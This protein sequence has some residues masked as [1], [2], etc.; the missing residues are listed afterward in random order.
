MPFPKRFCILLCLFQLS[1]CGG[2]LFAQTAAPTKVV[3]PNWPDMRFKQELFVFQPDGSPMKRGYQQVSGSPYLLPAC[4]KVTV[5]LTDIK[6]YVDVVGNLDLYSH[7]LIFL[8]DKNAPLLVSEERISEFKYADTI[9]NK[10]TFHKLINGYEPTGLTGRY[11]YFEVL[12]DGKISYLELKKV[13]LLESK[14]ELTGEKNSI[15]EAYRD[16]FIQVGGKLSRLGKRQKETL[17]AAM[18][19]KKDSVA[20]Y[21]Q[22]S[23]LTLRNNQEVM[24]LITYYNS[25]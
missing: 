5:Y 9:D 1:F 13:S 10:I 4:K 3:N 12:I 17:L 15:F 8:D 16:S 2:C 6:Q 11:D 7:E 19:D 22:K 20:A 23:R 21:V 24:Q 25:L 14:N 18:E